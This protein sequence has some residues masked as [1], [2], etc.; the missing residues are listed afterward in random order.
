MQLFSTPK[1]DLPLPAGRP[2]AA[3]P[4]PDELVASDQGQDALA[5]I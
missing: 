3:L 1:H 4:S 5:P 2:E